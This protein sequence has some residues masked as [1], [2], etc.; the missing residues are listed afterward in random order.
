MEESNAPE[1]PASRHFIYGI[2]YVS[3]YIHNFYIATRSLAIKRYTG[4]Q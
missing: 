3:S 2:Y 4:D 1:R